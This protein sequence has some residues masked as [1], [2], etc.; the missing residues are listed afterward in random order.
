MARNRQRAKER[1]AARRAARQGS[2]PPGDDLQEEVDLQVGAPPDELGRSDELLESL[3]ESELDDIDEAADRELELEAEEAGAF[4]DEPVDEIAPETATG[5]RGVRG[6]DTAAAGEQRS[7]LG[8]VWHFFQN[9]WAELQRVQ[10][11]DRKQVTTL[12]GVVLGFVLIAGG[13]LGLL[14]AIFSRVIDEII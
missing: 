4:S 3:E 11:P 10:W 1:Q 9:V 8:K 14:D 2:V 7:G 6:G 5:P 13:Y 12:T